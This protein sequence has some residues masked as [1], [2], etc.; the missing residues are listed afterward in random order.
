LDVGNAILV[1]KVQRER[2]K[3]VKGPSIETDVLLE[4]LLD[5]LPLVNRYL[6]FPRHL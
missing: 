6:S 4:S 2:P 5:K 3:G 1:A